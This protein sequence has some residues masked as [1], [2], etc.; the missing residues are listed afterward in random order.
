MTDQYPKT[1]YVFFAI[2]ENLACW[3]WMAFIFL[4][5]Q[6]IS[7]II[8]TFRLSCQPF[9]WMSINLIS[10]VF[11]IFVLLGVISFHPLMLL[12]HS[13]LDCLTLNTTVLQNL[14]FSFCCLPP[15]SAWNH[16]LVISYLPSPLCSGISRI[17]VSAWFSLRYIYLNGR[18]L[19]A[20]WFFFNF[21]LLTSLQCILSVCH[22][23]FY[24]YKNTIYRLKMYFCCILFYMEP[25]QYIPP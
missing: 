20:D 21:N 7:V 17:K 19:N 12:L 5:N 11:L 10:T 3:P 18:S 1:E 8:V 13:P 16:L 25:V 14:W 2:I 22:V 15:K 4:V 6:S 23:L 9:P 24:T